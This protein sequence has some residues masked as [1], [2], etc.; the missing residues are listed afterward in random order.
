MK[1]NMKRLLISAFAMCS[2][3]GMNAQGTIINGD[4]NG[5]GKITVADVTK[6]TEV[7]LGKQDPELISAKDSYNKSTNGYEFV[8]LGLPSG[9]LWLSKN[10]NAYYAWGEATPRNNFEWSNYSLC[11]GTNTS[12]NKYN[13]ASASGRV[14]W[15]VAYDPEEDPAR[16]VYG[17]DWESPTQEQ[18]QE[19][20]EN[21]LI[22]NSKEN[23]YIVL[24]SRK[25]SKQIRLYAGGT[26]NGTTGSRVG[27]QASCWT[28]AVCDS[29]YDCA[30]C[31]SI[32]SSD[33]SWARYV[34]D[35]SRGK[36]ITAVINPDKVDLTIGSIS[37]PYNRIYVPVGVEHEIN[38]FVIPNEYRTKT[39]HFFMAD[40]NPFPVKDN[41]VKATGSVKSTTMYAISADGSNKKSGKVTV[42][43]I[44]TGGYDFVDLGLPSGTLWAT[45]NVGA[46]NPT[47][48][49]DKYAWGELKTK[50]SFT[51]YNYD[52][53]QNSI[54]FYD[55]EYMLSTKDDVAYS[56]GEKHLRYPTQEEF[57]EL[58]NNTKVKEVWLR[59]T[60]GI[61]A[62]CW[63]FQSKVNG[64]KIIIP[65][66][67]SDVNEELSLNY[68]LRDTDSPS[69]SYAY[70]VLLSF[71]QDRK[72]QAPKRCNGYYIR[73]VLTTVR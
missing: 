24:A 41:I 60:K 63:E 32:N 62:L 20:F 64:N 56:V 35:R 33:E 47:D 68:W 54:T 50:D 5:D 17:G 16:I 8:D 65:A 40:A 39:L 12:I 42:T 34:A 7:L 13:C 37:F 1:G 44:A 25:N 26:L 27:T 43:S 22:V 71:K 66:N 55:G 23:G 61:E 2:V 10:T 30:Y 70:S 18:F 36:T 19:L 48:I 59:N 31:Y 51:Q 57:K 67:P 4:L 45:R 72:I 52:G 21:T 69:G 58:W 38:D 6:L 46:E 28:N 11:D 15:K 73:P 49:G 9:T 3:M 53:P 14:D 29:R